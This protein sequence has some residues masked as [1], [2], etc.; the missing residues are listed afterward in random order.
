MD[1]KRDKLKQ[2]KAAANIGIEEI[3]LN[4]CFHFR[5]FPAILPFWIASFF[6]FPLTLSESRTKTCDMAGKQKVRRYIF[7]YKYALNRNKS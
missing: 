1:P 6:V 2:T 5:L 3:S 7:P 4:C